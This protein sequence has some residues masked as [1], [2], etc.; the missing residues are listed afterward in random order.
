MVRL[1]PATAG[2]LGLQLRDGI[3]GAARLFPRPFSFRTSV[4]QDP[5]MFS[6][7]TVIFRAIIPLHCRKHLPA[8][9]EKPLLHVF[10]HFSSLLPLLSAV[11]RACPKSWSFNGAT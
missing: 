9:F 2:K 10:A 6:A 7:K 5:T 11:P 8:D 1:R 4:V 3:H